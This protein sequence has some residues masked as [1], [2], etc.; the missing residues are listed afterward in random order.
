[1]TRQFQPSGWT[2]SFILYASL[3]NKEQSTERGSSICDKGARPR[4][5]AIN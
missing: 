5:P 4:R 2:N 1:M 3:F